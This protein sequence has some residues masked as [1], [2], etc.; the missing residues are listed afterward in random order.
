MTAQAWAGC[1]ALQLPYIHCEN[2]R[3][4]RSGELRRLWISA[5]ADGGGP[6]PQRL[7]IL[8]D[9]PVTLPPAAQ[10]AQLAQRRAARLHAQAGTSG[11][12]LLVGLGH[13]GTDFYDEARR[14]RDFLPP[15]GWDAAVQA[16]QGRADALCHFLDE[17]LLPWLEARNGQEFT[18]VGLYGHS[19][20][21]LFALYKLLFQPGRFQAFF[22]ISPSLWWAEGWLLNQ[23]D[24]AATALAGRTVFLGIGAL[25][26]ALP[27]DSPQ[28]AAQHAQR[29]VQARF[30]RLGAELSA[31]AG[32]RTRLHIETFA[33]EDH[34][35]VLYPALTRALRWAL[36][37]DAAVPRD[38]SARSPLPHLPT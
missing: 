34:G 22:S 23:L 24:H 13:P 25:E 7:L 18:E 11:A 30:A 32:P 28:R 36:Q 38:K 6:A 20:G 16:E 27:G 17:E 19:F 1:E 33:G 35:S 9:G 15:G 31:R 2:L 26:Q 4:K 29:D 37:A 12:C 21:G 10:M 3:D 8:L 5:A 14:A